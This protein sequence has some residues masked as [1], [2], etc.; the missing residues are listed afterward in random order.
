MQL[1]KRSGQTGS[2]G[3][4]A[5]G[6]YTAHVHY[7]NATASV[8]ID[9]NLEDGLRSTGWSARHSR[10]MREEY[11]LARLIYVCEMSVDSSILPVINVRALITYTKY[12]RQQGRRQHTRAEAPV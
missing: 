7:W 2:D 9:M 4:Y 3:N 6:A 5:R 11:I 12:L 8:A 10:D 1:G